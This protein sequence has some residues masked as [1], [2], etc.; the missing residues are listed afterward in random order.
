MFSTKVQDLARKTQG[1]LIIKEYTTGQANTSHMRSLINELKLKK[2]FDH[3]I[4]F[5]D[6]LNIMA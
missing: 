2:D 4:I 5:V 3:D 1:K 6:Y